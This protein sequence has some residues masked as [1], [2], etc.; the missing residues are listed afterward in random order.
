MGSFCQQST[1]LFFIIYRASR[2]TY[3]DSAIGYVQVKREGNIC[4]V[5]GKIC[6]E[7][8]VR[9]KNYNVTLEVDENAEEIQSVLCHD[10]A[11]ALGTYL[12]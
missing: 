3:G 1:I 9:G 2:D 12:F 4:I 8:R 5:K 10:C 11:A 6:P 7:H